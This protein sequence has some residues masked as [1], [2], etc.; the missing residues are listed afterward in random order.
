MSYREYES[1]RDRA[2]VR[3]I[4]QEVGW[5]KDEHP[6]AIEWF[7]EEGRALVA[8]VDGGAEAVAVTAPG[9]VRHLHDDVPLSCV[10]AVATSRVARQRG[11]AGELT[12]AVMALDAADGAAIAGLG[13]FDQGFY[14]RLGFGTG[15]Y[16]RQNTFDPAALRVEPARRAPRRLT[17]DDWAVMHENRLQRRLAHG[18]CSIVSASTRFEAALSPHGFG[19]GFFDGPRGTLS[20]HLWLAVKQDVEFG[21]YRVKWMA[22]RTKEQL[23]ELL[24]VLRGLADQV[25]GVMMIDPPDIHMQSLLERPFRTNR[26]T[27]EGRYAARAISLSWWQMRICDLSACLAKTKLPGPGVRFNLSLTDPVARFLDDDAPWRGVAGDYIITL[28]PRSGA[29]RG[30]DDALPTM[31]ASVS[32]FTRLWLGVGPATGLAITDDLSAPADLLEEL[33]TA[34]RLPPPQPDWEF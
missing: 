26:L 19:L 28:G 27:E 1:A 17:K 24:G 33:D 3:R 13:M 11:L 29:E 14:N 2:A 18:A 32:A 21:P 25:H 7:V 9:T 22:W 6:D 30:C 31:I 8:D 10:A 23:L 34:L 16:V 4:F 15:A 20:H 5:L 12:A